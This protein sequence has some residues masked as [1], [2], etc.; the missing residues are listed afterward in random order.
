MRSFRYYIGVMRL[1]RVTTKTSNI[2]GDVLCNIFALR[3]SEQGYKPRR[4]H[5]S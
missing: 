3:G 5:S 4:R 1:L 2:Q